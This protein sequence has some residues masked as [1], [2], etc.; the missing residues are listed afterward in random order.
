LRGIDIAVEDVAK[1]LGSD[2]DGVPHIDVLGRD[3]SR[4]C[5]GAGSSTTMVLGG[6]ATASMR[7]F[8]YGQRER[9]WSMSYARWLE[10]TMAIAKTCKLNGC[11]DIVALQYLRQLAE[12]CLDIGLRRRREEMAS[13][14]CETPG[15]GISGVAAGADARSAAVERGGGGGGRLRRRGSMSA[16]EAG[17]ALRGRIRGRLNRTM[18]SSGDV[19]SS[20]R[21]AKGIDY[22]RTGGS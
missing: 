3:R 21:P 20:S 16:M 14:Q 4:A 11:G 12:P 5:D 22:G 2:D 7:A 18:L 10:K 15:R 6:A 13:P 1:R 8:G 19:W 9:C 17:A